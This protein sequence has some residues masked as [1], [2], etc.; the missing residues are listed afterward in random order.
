MRILETIQIQNGKVLQLPYHQA[1]MN[2]ARKQLWQCED[3]IELA[4]ILTIPEESK[5]GIVRCRVVYQQEIEEV[6]FIPYQW[7]TI[8]KIK[9]IETS[10]IDYAIKWLER[11]VFTQLLQE[12][13]DAD[14]LII[15][16]NGWVSDATIANLAF[17]DG[18]QWFTPDTPL[19]KGTKRQYLLDTQQIQEKAIKVEDLKHFEKVCLINTFRD[20]S[21]EEAIIL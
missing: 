4:Q 15:T 21:H 3:D 5:G 7:K 20:L 14:E 16:Q 19:L 6:Q 2:A 11:S 8:R 10:P 13:P 12:N 1:R 18:K 17:W 9:V